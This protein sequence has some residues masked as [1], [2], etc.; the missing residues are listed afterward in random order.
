MF[1]LL[2]IHLFDITQVIIYSTNDNN[3]IP[4]NESNHDLKIIISIRNKDFSTDIIK[5]DRSVSGYLK[6]VA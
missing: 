4:S 6:D 5:N 3:I 1:I 2:L